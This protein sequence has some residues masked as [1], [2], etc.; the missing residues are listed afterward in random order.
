MNEETLFIAVAAFTLVF[1]AAELLDRWMEL[2][3]QKRRDKR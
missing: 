3:E 1:V 2:R